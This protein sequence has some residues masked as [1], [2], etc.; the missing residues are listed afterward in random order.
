[1]RQVLADPTLQPELD[2]LGHVRIPLLSDEEISALLGRVARLRPEDGFAPTGRGPTYHC[3]LVDRS[4]EY[5]R[6]SFAVL[7]SAFAHHVERVLDGYQILNANFYVK[8]PGTGAFTAHQNWPAISDL[9][10]TSITVW[11]PLGDVV[12][13]NGTIQVVPRSHKLVPHVEAPN[14]PAFFAGYADLLIRDYLEPVPMRAGEALVFDDNLIHWSQDNMSDRPRIA[15][16]IVCV[17]R[18]ATPTFFH[19]ADGE[20]F[21]LIAADSD[22]FLQYNV[23]QL[24]ARQDDWISLGF[25]DSPNRPV[26]PERFAELLARRGQHPRATPPAA[27]QSKTTTGRRGRLRAQVGRH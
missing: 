10:D 4:E 7:K 27:S 12:A 20:R 13:E 5:R 24:H 11:C 18:D 16:Q 23:E 15:V 1:M 26:P 14:S 3:S 9:D 21:E 25:I 19:K 22:F 8:P 6:E 2:E 17:P